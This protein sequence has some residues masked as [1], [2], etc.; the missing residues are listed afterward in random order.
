M[1]NIDNLHSLLSHPWYIDQEYANSYL[2]LLKEL[3]IA[4]IKPNEKYVQSE[5]FTTRAQGEKTFNNESHSNRVAILS[6]KNPIVKYDQFFGVVG[7]KTMIRKLEAISL[8][9]DIAGVVLDIDSGGGQCYGTPLFHDFIKNYPKPVVAYTDGLMCS[10]AY[11]IAS[12][13]SH[14]IANKRSDA[15]GSIGAYAYVV[16]WDGAK[17]KLGAKVHMVYSSKSPEKNKAFEDLLKGNYDQYIKEE[18]DPQVE[19]L[20]KDIKDVRPLINEEVFKGTTYNAEESL[21][22]HLIDQIGSFDDAIN[23]VFEFASSSKKTE[24]QKENGNNNKN[25][26]TMKEIQNNLTSISDILGK[27]DG[28]KL[29]S[30]LFSDK[31]GVFLTAGQLEL[32]ESELKK[33]KDDFDSQVKLADGVRDELKNIKQ[34]VKESLT[35]ASLQA[36]DSCEGSIYL[37]GNLLNKYGLQPGAMTTT[38]ASKGDRF[39]DVESESTN[40]IDS[41][42]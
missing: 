18:L 6:I 21:K 11:Y 23:K 34:A 38:I 1:G 31:K 25:T 37:L 42:I 24:E 16:N 10:A 40:I 2:T 19:Q 30:K 5:F 13:C 28:L 33:R 32:I 27:E 36:A 41:I 12:A 20:I 39:E 17:E 22:N 7:T 26:L 4:G 14:I 15:I 29:S 8:D 35:K 3:V 9:E